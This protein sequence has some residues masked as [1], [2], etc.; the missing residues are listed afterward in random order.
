MKLS[1]NLFM[2][3]K[4][5]FFFRFIE[6]FF[7]LNKFTNFL[8][9]FLESVFFLEDRNFLLKTIGFSKKSALNLKRVSNFSLDTFKKNKIFLFKFYK[10]YLLKN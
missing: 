3:K 8:K 5:N 7:G 1:R 4:K 9:N 2:K 10:N 6:I